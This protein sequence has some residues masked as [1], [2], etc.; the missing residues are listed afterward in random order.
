M[1]LGLPNALRILHVMHV[2]YFD[3]CIFVD[4]EHVL[5]TCSS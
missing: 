3:A 1:C 4:Y 5:F 2:P